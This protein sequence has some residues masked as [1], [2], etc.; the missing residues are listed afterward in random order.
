MPSMMLR[1][2][3]VSGTAVVVIA[4]YGLPLALCPLRWARTLGWVA[5]DDV[6]LARYLGRS[7]GAAVLT[8]ALIVLY[9]AQQPQLEGLATWVAAFALG[10]ESLPHFVGLVERSQPLFE[11][12]EGF[13][14][15]A[16]AVVFAVLAA[17]G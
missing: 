10:M 15:A 11:T 3:L 8:L 12:I 5:P 7:L 6:R 2:L 14:F 4:A 9:A 16:L 1:P 17:R 13:V